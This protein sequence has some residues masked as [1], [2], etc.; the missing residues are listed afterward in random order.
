MIITRPPLAEWPPQP[1]NPA[2]PFLGKPGSIGSAVFGRAQMAELRE[3]KD[4]V[5]RLEKLEAIATKSAA[6]AFSYV[7]GSTDEGTLSPEQLRAVVANAEIIRDVL[8]PFDSGV[9]PAETPD[10]LR[11]YAAAEA[12]K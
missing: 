10:V 9:R 7:L 6:D 2:P 5:A 1:I 3:A 12:P 4:N 11:G 8:A